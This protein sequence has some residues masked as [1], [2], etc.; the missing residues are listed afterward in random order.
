MSLCFPKLSMVLPKTKLFIS[1]K[2]S[3]SKSFLALFLR[4]V[5]TSMYDF[6][7]A[8]WLN[9]MTLCIF[10]KTDPWFNACFTFLMWIT[11]LLLSC[12]L[13]KQHVFLLFQFSLLLVNHYEVHAIVLDTEHQL[14]EDVRVKQNQYHI[15]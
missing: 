14:Q 4:L 7:Q 3:F 13:A 1:S 6:N 10:F 5:F 2:K 15:V 12:K 9:L 11:Y 8:F